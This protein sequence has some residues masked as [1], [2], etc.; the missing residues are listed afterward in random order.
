MVRYLTED[1]VKKLLTM[2]LALERV[3]AAHRA[4]G[5][6]RA[7]DVPRERIHLPIGTQHV[8][9]AAA[10]D[11]GYIGFKNYYTRPQGKAFYVQLIG[12]DSGRLEALIEAV[13]MSM[14]RTGA[15]SGVATRHL[16]NADASI[17][18]QIGA[19]YQGIGQ[20]EGVCGVRKI[21][22]AN[23]YSRNRDRL[24][25]FCDTMSRKLAIEVVPAESAEAAVRGAHVV[26][27]ITKSATP[28]LLGQWLEPGQ[29]VNAAGSNAL[30][31]REI[32]EETVN[33]C[34]VVT[35]DGRGTARKESGDL[36]PAV[37][38]GSLRWDTLTEIGEIIAGRAPGR[39]STRQITLYES[40]GMGLQDLYVGAAVLASAREKNAGT[41]LPIGG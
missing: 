7:V 1:D 16:A 21:R 25:G 9:Q 10:P 5:E 40:H 15:A 34:Q 28:V 36:L 30:S 26:N 32:D 3:E 38:K 27:V 2:P 33:K 39:A 19:G 29:H 24:L 18:G 41:D 22:R 14:V 4:L 12:T 6:R 37:E 20:L 31:R 17:V 11:I 23:V 35:V 13:H 8:L